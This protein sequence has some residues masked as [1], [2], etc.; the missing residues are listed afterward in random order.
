MKEFSPK[1]FNAEN[2]AKAFREVAAHQDF[3]IIRWALL[4]RLSEIRH[5]LIPNTDAA[6]LNRA[7]GKA[8]EI[9]WVLACFGEHPYG[10]L[11]L[12]DGIPFGG[13]AAQEA[14]QTPEIGG[15]YPGGT[16]SRP[17]L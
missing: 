1:R 13:D 9:E 12:A 16:G 2:A 4:S 8:E 17:P 3:D 14:G 5:F 11:P 7:V 15:G 6:Q 10:G